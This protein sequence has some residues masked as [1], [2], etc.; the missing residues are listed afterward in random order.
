MFEPA[1]KK[2][3]RESHSHRRL[4]V[5]QCLAGHGLA[6]ERRRLLRDIRLV[7]DANRYQKLRAALTDLGPVFASFGIY[8]SS[9]A[10]LLPANHCLELAGI[11]DKATAS[12][13]H[14]VRQ[15]IDT[16]LGF[17]PANGFA[18]FDEKP[19]ESRLLFQSHVARLFSGEIVVVR[20]L[21]PELED[22]LDEDLE[23]LSV[24]SKTLPELDDAIDDF[25]QSLKQETDFVSAA[26]LMA[27]L[28]RDSPALEIRRVPLSRREFCTSKVLTF[29]YLSGSSLEPFRDVENSELA[30][31]LLLIWLE[32]SLMG[33][34]FAVDPRPENI[35]IAQGQHIVFTGGTFAKLSPDVKTNLYDYLVAVANQDPDRACSCLLKEMRQ[36]TGSEAEL[37]HRIRQVVPFRDGGWTSNGDG[38]TL[39]EYVLVH[40][41][42]AHECG[43]RAHPLVLGFFRG[44]FQVTATARSLAP[45][46]DLLLKGLQ[47]LRMEMVFTQFRE[48]LTLNQ[49]S[50][51]FDRYAAIMADFPERLNHALTLAAEGNA[52][53]QDDKP[54]FHSRKNATAVGIG[55]LLLLIALVLV[56]RQLSANAWIENVSGIVFLMIGALLIRVFSHG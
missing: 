10:D 20:M 3:P 45:T 9:R 1:R 36:T 39:V 56:S 31:R 51:K 52:R 11:A 8:L 54:Q 41:R 34:T 38:S 16:E 26:A 23:L 12:S 48:L 13:P 22:L 15:L 55:L 43:Y 27:E 42:L 19:F 25:R 30:S 2:S 5:E 47:D 40:W 18:A 49:M 24:L 44:L 46:G 28:Y 17:L 7:H 33:G 50:D 29:E 6:P 53:S 35:F 37:R 4:E 32:Q 21:H 14:L